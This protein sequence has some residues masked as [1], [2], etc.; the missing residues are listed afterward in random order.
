M[1]LKTLMRHNTVST[2]PKK[3]QKAEAAILHLNMTGAAALD[4]ALDFTDTD[5]L[6]IL[7]KQHPARQRL[8]NFRRAC[9]QFEFEFN[10]IA[11]LRNLSFF[12]DVRA[13][14]SALSE[15]NI[16]ALIEL[17]NRFLEGREETPYHA[18]LAQ[19]YTVLN[20]LWLHNELARQWR[21]EIACDV[22]ITQQG[23]IGT[24]Y[25]V[26]S[27]IRNL[28]A[29]N[30]ERAMCMLLTEVERLAH[31]NENWRTDDEDKALKKQF[32]RLARQ[33]NT[34]KFGTEV[35]NHANQKEKE[36]QQL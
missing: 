6:A 23:N 3:I 18:I 20:T 34:I 21:K 25:E 29:V 5:W 19:G 11:R 10:E 7:P 24:C 9:S 36:Y 1:Q 14:A 27:D 8:A 26:G 22:I 33:W 4:V 13:K 32:N 12:A 30:A 35:I 15:K 31:L 2:D 17:Y 28:M 16:Q